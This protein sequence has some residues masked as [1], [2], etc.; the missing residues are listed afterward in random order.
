MGIVAGT[1]TT[2]SHSTPFL[3]SHSPYRKLHTILSYLSST[4]HP[5]TSL[6]DDR[7][8]GE[9]TGKILGINEPQ[10]GIVLL[11][12]FST[13]WALYSFSSP[14]LGGQLDEDGLGL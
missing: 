8:S 12:V 7:L 6:V 14:S 13:V 11:S 9:G 1:H 3:L 5:S 10:Q 2:T 4:S